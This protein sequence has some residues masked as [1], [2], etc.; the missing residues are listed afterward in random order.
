[1]GSVWA[2]DQMTDSERQ[3]FEKEVLEAVA[4]YKEILRGQHAQLNF[5]D[6]DSAKQSVKALAAKLQRSSNKQIVRLY[7][8]ARFQELAFEWSDDRGEASF[9]MNDIL[10]DMNVILDDIVKMKPEEM[11]EKDKKLPDLWRRRIETKLKIARDDKKIHTEPIQQ[12]LDLQKK[13]IDDFKGLHR[14]KDLAEI[15]EKLANNKIPASRVAEATQNVEKT[16]RMLATMTTHLNGFQ[17]KLTRM[18]MKWD[19]PIVDLEK[20]QTAKEAVIEKWKKKMQDKSNIDWW[21]KIQS[22]LKIM[23]HPVDKPLPDET[24]NT[25]YIAKKGFVQAI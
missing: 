20:K 5:N 8:I 24:D 14:Y 9:V 17:E 7:A 18:T 21:G 12:D 16:E 15:K 2:A 13:N 23:K 3:I 10:D 1:M 11:E 4:M 19:A 25:L 22:R 6:E